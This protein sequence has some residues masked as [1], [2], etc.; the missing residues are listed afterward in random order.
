MSTGSSVRQ[1]VRGSTDGSRAI[2]PPGR[3]TLVP[4]W[5]VDRKWWRNR[6][7]HGSWLSRRVRWDVSIYD[8]N[9]VFAPEAIPYAIAPAGVARPCAVSA[10][11]VPGRRTR[12]D[13]MSE[14]PRCFHR[15]SAPP[16]RRACELKTP[17]EE[18]AVFGL[19]STELTIALLIAIALM[20]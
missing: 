15:N 7:L 20:V 8:R 9:V 1:A 10:H 11:R 3:A 12:V 18:G 2:D 5:T 6:R 17:Q 4:S 13:A 19:N 14:I 16:F